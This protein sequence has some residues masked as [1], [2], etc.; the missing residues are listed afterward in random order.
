MEP[1]LKAV[2]PPPLLFIVSGPSGAGKGT[3]VRGI[4][5]VMP[6]LVRVP[7]YTTRARRPDEVDGSD[8]AFVSKPEFM[9]LVESGSIY[10]FTRTYSDDYYGAPTRLL[11]TADPA[12]LICELD[13]K[14]AFRTKSL[15]VRR[16]VSI[17]ITP[18]DVSVLDVRI[19]ARGVEFNHKRRLDLA[20]DQISLA[21]AYDYCLV[22]D[23]AGVLTQEMQHI[24]RSAFLQQRG[25]TFLAEHWQEFDNTLQAP[26]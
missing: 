21:W 4:C 5:R 8:Y 15:G 3:A 20:R 7:T 25:S 23:N 12:P 13:P 19:A 22:N 10:E 6:E 2:K 24:V 17:F 9:A 26:S 11:T 1:C 16:V 14:G 18:R